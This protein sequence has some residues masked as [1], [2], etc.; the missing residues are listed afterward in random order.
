MQ[1][2]D[3]FDA[4]YQSAIGPELTQLEDRRKVVAKRHKQLAFGVFGGFSLVAIVMQ[5][6]IPVTGVTLFFLLVVYLWLTQLESGDLRTTYKE[7]VIPKLLARIDPNLQYSAQGYLNED[8][9]QASGFFNGQYN[10]YQAEDLVHGQ[11]RGVDFGVCEVHAIL[12][13]YKKRTGSENRTVVEK[14]IFRGFFF[15]IGLTHPAE[16]RVV[17]TPRTKDVKILGIKVSMPHEWLKDP[18]V[19]VDDPAFE[20]RFKIRS[21]SQEAALEGLQPELRQ[22]LMRLSGKQ[23]RAV[24]LALVR[25]RAYLALPHEVDMFEPNLSASLFDPEMIRAY[26]SAMQF[27]TSL[28]AR[29]SLSRDGG[30][31]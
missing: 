31:A 12:R 4:W 6:P 13:K 16:A 23:G 30:V 18:E 24:C 20:R 5:L 2:L 17:V 15:E 21:S 27:I 1:A 28:P 14:T 19:S 8:S 22:H 29:L 11:V 7:V 10:V 26:L 25:D 9:F 3:D